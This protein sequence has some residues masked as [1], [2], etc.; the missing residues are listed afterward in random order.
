MKQDMELEAHWGLVG[1]RNRTRAP[2]GDL[3]A[4]ERRD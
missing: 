2:G 4:R 1:K 3:G